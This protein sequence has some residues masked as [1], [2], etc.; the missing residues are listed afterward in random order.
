MGRFYASARSR[1]ALMRRNKLP[2]LPAGGGNCTFSPALL[3]WSLRRHV[4]INGQILHLFQM[5]WGIDKIARRN[6]RCGN[7]RLFGLTYH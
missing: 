7:K 5:D 4:A 3:A 1:K 6:A 2:F